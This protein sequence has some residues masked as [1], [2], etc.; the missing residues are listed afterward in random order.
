VSAPKV[1]FQVRLR[2]TQRLEQIGDRVATALGCQFAPAEDHEFEPGDALEATTLGLVIHVI[3]EPAVEPGSE[4]VYVLRGLVRPDVEAE[5]A[6]DAPTTSIT[7]Y[8]LAVMQVLDD[9]RWYVADR[10][11][12]LAEAGLPDGD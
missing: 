7:E 11:E 1:S 10:R 2:S 6:V 8:V 5:L 12:L 4:A 9:P 3:G